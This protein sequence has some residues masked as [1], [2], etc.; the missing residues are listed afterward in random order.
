MFG[1]KRSVTPLVG[2]TGDPPSARPSKKVSSASLSGG[3][4]H[5][6]LSPSMADAPSAKYKKH[7]SASAI[8]GAAAAPISAAAASKMLFL[9]NNVYHPEV[10]ELDGATGQDLSIEP[11]VVS[12]S[13]WQAVTCET[14]F[15]CQDDASN[16]LLHFELAG[17][18]DEGEFPHVG[19]PLVEDPS[20]VGLHVSGDEV[21]TG[22]VLL[23]IQG[24]KVSGYTAA[25]V[26][27]WFKH[28][29][30]SKNPVLVRS[31]PK[32]RTG[33][34]FII[35]LLDD[36]DPSILP[37]ISLSIPYTYIA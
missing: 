21:R 31:V 34:R 8:P 35:A 12:G 23:E 17:G 11:P 7:H 30:A 27:R 5:Q 26:A 13:D 22:S 36:G 25:D 10:G 37:A 14:Y 3:A 6:N 33:S 15:V 9:E 20:D 4:G 2:G 24:R 16:C 19:A 32:G 18:A 1:G 29:L 28:C